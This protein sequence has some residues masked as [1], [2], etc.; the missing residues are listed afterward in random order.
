MGKRTRKFDQR[1]R[2]EGGQGTSPEEEIV[3]QIKKA[4]VM[5]LDMF[6]IDLLLD[7]L[8]DKLRYDGKSEWAI[9]MERP[10]VKWYLMFYL[11]TEKIRIKYFYNRDLYC[12]DFN[13]CQEY[14]KL[15]K[16]QKRQ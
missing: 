14:P 12:Q 2:R 15:E 16:G 9:R 1:R 5:F 8:Y 6:S 7:D 10:C 3:F 13:E 4:H 11:W